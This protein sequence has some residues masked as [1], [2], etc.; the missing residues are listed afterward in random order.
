MHDW[1]RVVPLFSELDEAELDHLARLAGRIEV[2]KKSVVVQEGE[3]GEALY[4]ILEGSVKISQ[5]SNDGREIV[6]SLLGEGAFFGEM[7]LLDD[8]PR[9]ATVMTMEDC[10]LAQIKRADFVELLATHPNI[11]LKVLA[12]VVA[13]LRRTSQ[14]LARI[15][16]MDVP[17]RLYAY[18]I[19]HCQ[20]FGR[21]CGEDGW[22]QTTLPTHQLLADQL[23]TSRET[24]S[25][26]ISSLKKDGILKPGEGRGEMRVDVRTLQTLVQ[27]ME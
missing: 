15:S 19:D 26:A 20:R 6:L 16:T 21:A 25:R 12:E 13:R 9:S 10:Q 8:Q 17:H 14:L 3:P 22:M 11:A 2:P 7:S 24:I 1:L 4:I 5:F 27:A 23:S 18:L